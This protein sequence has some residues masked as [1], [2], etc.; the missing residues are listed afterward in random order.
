MSDF[1]PFE[2]I[3]EEELREVI[4]EGFRLIRNIIPPD[5]VTEQR[6][7]AWRQYAEELKRNVAA[8]R[9]SY[10]GRW[11]TREEHCRDLYEISKANVILAGIP[12]VEEDLRGI[13]GGQARDDYIAIEQ[14]YS[15]T[16]KLQ[17]LYHELAHMV[18]R[19]LHG[20]EF[21]YLAAPELEF[22]AE[23]VSQDLLKR[24][25]LP[26]AFGHERIIQYQRQLS[27]VHASLQWVVK[28]TEHCLALLR[29]HERDW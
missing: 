3:S 14:Q 12:V 13:M 9:N 27:D 26:T 1:P 21:N 2:G 7:A 5:P 20:V 29:F 24:Q 6:N 18:S 17:I 11:L 8:R 16:N 25:G 15:Y 22:E 23:C 10:S 28:I 19:I 4:H